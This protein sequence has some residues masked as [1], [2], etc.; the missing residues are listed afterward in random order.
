MEILNAFTET[1]SINSELISEGSLS[2]SGP[3]NAPRCFY[4]LP[5]CLYRYIMNL[6]ECS[7]FDCMLCMCEKLK[8][9]NNVHHLRVPKDRFGN[10]NQSSEDFLNLMS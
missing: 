2:Q 1:E 9:N 6:N 7:V 8:E 4:Q 10:T 5:T 3:Q